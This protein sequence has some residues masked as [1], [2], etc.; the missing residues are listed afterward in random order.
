[1]SE[2]HSRPSVG[3]K[4]WLD[5]YHP[6]YLGYMLSLCCVLFISIVL[7]YLDL[8][9]LQ[10]LAATLADAGGRQACA[11]QQTLSQAISASLTGW[12]KEAISANGMSTAWLSGG[13]LTVYCLILLTTAAVS[14]WQTRILGQLRIASRTDI[15][16]EVLRNLLNKDDQFF[17]TH[18]TA[19]VTSRLS[20]DVE[21]VTQRRSLAVDL[22][23]SVITVLVA[24]LYLFEQNEKIALVGFLV[25]VSG[26]MLSTYF[27][28]SRT[29]LDRSY[30][31]QDDKVKSAIEGYVTV[32]PEAQV[33]NW[34]EVIIDRF[35]TDQ[36]PRTGIWRNFIYREGLV[37]VTNSLAYMAAFAAIVWVIIANTQSATGAQQVATGCGTLLAAVPV[38]IRILPQL[39]FTVADL[40]R[41]WFDY[42]ESANSVARLMEYETHGIGLSGFPA[43]SG[44]DESVVSRQP[45]AFHLNTPAVP[46]PQREEAG[47]DGPDLAI[48]IGPRS[49]TAIVG[50]SGSGK[51]T[52]IQVLLG[53]T[54]MDTISV[55]YGDRDVRDWSA[56]ERART[57]AYMP[58]K[59]ALL[60]AS[61]K[62]NLIFGRT[63]VD[64]T[65]DRLSE[66]DCELLDDIGLLQI[67]LDKV[68]N[69]KPTNKSRGEVPLFEAAE[70]RA[71]ERHLNEFRQTA[72]RNIMSQ[73]DVKL[74]PFSPKT[75]APHHPLVDHL[76]GG[77]IDVEA[78]FSILNPRYQSIS[79]IVTAWLN[80]RK[81]ARLAKTETGRKLAAQTERLL[82]ATRGTLMQS[83][84]AEQFNR[85][86]AD[87]TLSPPAWL[88]RKTIAERL[89]NPGAPRGAGSK[90]APG[91]PGEAGLPSMP[92]V[93]VPGPGEATKTD[94]QETVA[95]AAPVL[96][97]WAA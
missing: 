97:S 53:R 62:Q 30:Q 92:R 57:V 34:F 31:E 88:L 66:A 75:A 15:E 59:E 86:R 55:R 72:C 64:G 46:S 16:R 90:D 8:T 96:R 25:I 41:N 4:S 49:L 20:K 43:H 54:D 48:E 27:N 68:L 83:G 13:V 56:L 51:S 47:A 74:V 26:V 9:V 28:R 71:F 23:K 78:F 14:F 40:G 45:Q 1:M 2:K 67:A 73:L 18:D 22:L 21:R 81:L 44:E 52:L 63:R 82:Q 7:T 93:K 17:E 33:G 76:V 91:P 70:Q 39:Y 89:N 11:E 3:L 65:E 87:S 5:F 50:G 24:F 10:A 94:G 80:R 6:D 95:L 79:G 35:R 38:I 61:M 85:M 29:A 69:L 84:S 32:T 77:S 36:K 12:L 60:N 19:E 42:R 37:S 58:Q